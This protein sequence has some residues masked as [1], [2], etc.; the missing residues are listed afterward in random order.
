VRLELLGAQ[1][2]KQGRK[3]VAMA[4]SNGADRARQQFAA[5]QNVE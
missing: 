5:A 3:R 4:R 1:A 2:E